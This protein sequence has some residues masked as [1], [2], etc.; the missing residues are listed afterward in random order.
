MVKIVS[1]RLTSSTLGNSRPCKTLI[2]HKIHSIFILVVVLLKVMYNFHFPPMSFMVR[3]KMCFEVICIVSY[4]LLWL[5]VGFSNLIIINMVT[6][7]CIFQVS[8]LG[9][10]IM[11][12][13]KSDMCIF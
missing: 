12:M 2:L 11:I 4:N 13:L 10:I 1:I 3:T 5:H 8:T 6:Y 7:R 9:L